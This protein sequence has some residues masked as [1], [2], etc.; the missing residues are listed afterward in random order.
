MSV[1]VSLSSIVTASLLTCR[2]PP[3]PPPPPSQQEEVCLGSEVRRIA[4]IQRAD[5]VI[6]WLAWR[7]P[8][9]V[10]ASSS[11][12]HA[13]TPELP[14]ARAAPAEGGCNNRLAESGSSSR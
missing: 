7:P 2:T 10:V 6:G 1:S 8:W 14:L 4:L 12:V 11:G 13:N 9:G 3:P 5:V